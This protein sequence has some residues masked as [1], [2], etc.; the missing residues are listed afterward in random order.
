MGCRVCELGSHS[1]GTGWSGP[2]SSWAD[3]GRRLVLEAAIRL[4]DWVDEST[5][6]AILRYRLFGLGPTSCFQTRV[7]R[8]DGRCWCCVSWRQV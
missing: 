2:R 8:L 7:W 4:P 3:K 1:G 6:T 5:E